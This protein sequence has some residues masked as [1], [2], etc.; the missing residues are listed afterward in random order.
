MQ[1]K[2]KSKSSIMSSKL[3]SH[4]SA[5]NNVV[6]R[7][8][9]EAGELILEYFEGMRDMKLAQ[10]GDGSPVTLADQEAEVL[11]EERLLAVLPDIPVIGE[12]SHASGR[13]IDLKAQEYFW[14]V[15]PL[16]GTRAF[17][18]G[19]G[20]FTVNIALIHNSEPVLGVV[21]APEK[22]EMY[23]GFF[24]TDGNAHAS[25]FFE[26]STR[27]KD[28][29]ARTMPKK[30]LTIMSSGYYGDSS[31]QDKFLD[32]LKVATIV[33]RASSIK[34]CTI[35]SGKADLY[36]RFGPTC[37]WDTAAGHALLRAAGG[38]I[39]DM[40]GNPLRYGVGKDDLINPDFIAASNDVL[41]HFWGE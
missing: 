36:P 11:I 32:G 33:R 15:D 2:R 17:V 5:L 38:D 34:I 14:L 16:D 27:E 40:Q 3:L 6:K 28:L 29:R 12:E 24:D 39:R 37:E 23:S 31:A 21:Y 9:V 4:R 25:R 30:G 26:E 1:P 20:D 22:G 18:R 7:I 19:E 10:K 35:A 8:A 41:D 13:R